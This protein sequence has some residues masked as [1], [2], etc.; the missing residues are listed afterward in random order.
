VRAT[1]LLLAG[2][3]TGVLTVVAAACGA[4]GP[5]SAVERGSAIYGANCAQCHGADL[6]GTER[7]PSLLDPAYRSLTDADIAD[8]VRNGVAERVWDFGPMPANGALSDTQID[9]IVEY[10]RAEQAATAVSP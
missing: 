2:V 3:G 6:D 7:G 4:D 9:A 5:Q 8:A 1:R 10:L